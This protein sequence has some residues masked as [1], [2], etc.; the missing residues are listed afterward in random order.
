VLP[1]DGLEFDIWRQGQEIGFRA[2]VPAR[3]VTVLDFGTARLA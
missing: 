2:R 1:G 3:G